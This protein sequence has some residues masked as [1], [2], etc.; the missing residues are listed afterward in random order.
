MEKLLNNE[1]FVKK[2]DPQVVEN[3]KQNL[4]KYKEMAKINRGI[5]LEI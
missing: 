3:Y 1:E 4:L 2:A 5:L